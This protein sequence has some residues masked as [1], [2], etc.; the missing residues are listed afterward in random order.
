[1]GAEDTR[2]LRKIEDA[3]DPAG[4]AEEALASSPRKASVCSE[5]ILMPYSIKN[6]ILVYFLF[7]Q[8]SAA[9]L[10]VLLSNRHTW[11]QYH[12]LTVLLLYV[13]QVRLLDIY[14][15]FFL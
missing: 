3:L 6:H 2:L 8:I 4:E 7:I 1:M 11:R 12:P 10:R 14:V 15:L 9:N 5:L 13:D